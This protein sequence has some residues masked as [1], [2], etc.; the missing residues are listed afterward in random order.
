MKVGDLVK[1]YDGVVGIVIT[2]PRM[3]ADV[4]GTM[5]GDI[6]HMVDIVMP[7]GSELYATDELEVVNESR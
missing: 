2:T 1:D 5:D 4:N 3:S 7:W 6:Y